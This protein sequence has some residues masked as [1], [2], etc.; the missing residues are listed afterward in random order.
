MWRPCIEKLKEKKS[1]KCPGQHCL[2]VLRVGEVSP[3]L[4]WA[5][6]DNLSTG[7][8]CPRLFPAPACTD[9]GP[10]ARQK[11]HNSASIR[12]GFLFTQDI[13]LYKRHEE[14]VSQ[15]WMFL[16]WMKN[17]SA[18][19]NTEKAFFLQTVEISFKRQLPLPVSLIPWLEPRT[20][21]LTYSLS[22]FYIYYFK[23]SV[24]K[25]SRL[26]LNLW[27]FCFRFPEWWDYML[28]TPFPVNLVFL[29]VIEA[30]AKSVEMRI[31]PLPGPAAGISWDLLLDSLEEHIPKREMFLLEKAPHLTSVENQ[32]KAENSIQNEAH[33]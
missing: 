23:M 29:K 16:Q 15:R 30:A 14:I 22:P 33:W 12:C 19:Q 20:F 25:L 2:E 7:L 27:S 4:L 10:V 5:L 9:W 18:D 28:V 26:G 11:V 32:S 24:I 8:G 6:S 3:P 31:H 1:H 13:C 17:E 21:W